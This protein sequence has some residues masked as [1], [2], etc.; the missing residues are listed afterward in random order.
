MYKTIVALASILII[1]SGCSSKEEPK[2]PETGKEASAPVAPVRGGK[3]LEVIQTSS[4]SYL[5]I[6]EEAGEVWVAVQKMDVKEGE[7]I[8]FTQSMEMKDFKGKEANKTFESILFV[9]D[10][11]KDKASFGGQVES[12]SDLPSD[13]KHPEQ[14]GVAKE[15]V[16]VEKAAGGVTVSEVFSKKSELK[17]K[18]VKIR[19]KVTKVNAEIMNRNWIHIQD[20]TASGNGYDLTLTSAD[21]PT[22][23]QIILIEGIVSVDKDFGA[24]YK[25]DVIVEDAKILEKK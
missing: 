17:D 8:Y 7:N 14:A 1:F 19:G 25:Y 16:K 23:G 22:V 4:Y 15:E 12:S 21:V 9:N 18:K 5:R 11:S 20:G 6:D 10:P 2:T 13:F 24:G 3:V